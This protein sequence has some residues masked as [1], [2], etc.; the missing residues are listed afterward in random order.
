MITLV[1]K[2]HR[3]GE[4]FSKQEVAQSLEHPGRN[5]RTQSAA[6]WIS[7][8]STLKKTILL[9]SYCR[10]K[11]NPRRH[12]YRR[13]FTPDVTGMT[14]GYISN[15]KCDACK[16]RTENMGGG[17]AYVHEALYNQVA[18]DPTVA[19]RNARA[20]AKAWSVTRALKL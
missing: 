4:G 5:T 16:Q 10:V 20:S 14:D 11:F 9:C 12:H 18:V 17:T 7:D 6:S 1:P 15:G 19:R 3:L 13:L 8:L 2:H